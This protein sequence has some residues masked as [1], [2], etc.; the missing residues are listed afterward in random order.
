ME[1]LTPGEWAKEQVKRAP[2][3]AIAT[4]IVTM[5]LVLSTFI[6][7]APARTAADNLSPVE[8][9]IAEEEPDVIEEIDEI[10]PEEPDL[11]P[12]PDAPPV[13]DADAVPVDAPL[14]DMTVDTDF[15]DDVTSDVTE[16]TDPFPME[17]SRKMATIGTEAGTGGFR[18]VL[19]ARSPGGRRSAARR[20][21]MPKGTDKDIL[22]GLRWL[23]KAQNKKTGGWGC[24]QWGGKRD[25]DAGVTGLAL[26]AYLGFGC[27]DKQPAEFASTVK[28]AMKYLVD[29]QKKFGS[30]GKNTGWFGERMYSQGICTMAVSEAYAM[31]GRR[32]CKKSAQAGLDY[33][34]SKQPAY[35]AFSYT[36]PGGDVSVTGFQI[37]AIKSA[38]IAG[39]KVPKEAKDKTLKFLEICMRKDFSTPYGIQPALKVQTKPGKTTMTAATL[40]GRLFMGEKNTSVNS[41]GQADYLMANNRLQRTAQSASCLYEIYYMSLSMFNMGGKYWRTWNKEF[42]K[43]LRA[44]QVKSGPET[45][46]W[47]VKGIR[48][49]G[50]GGRVYST[51][52]ACMALEVYFRYLPTYK[53]FK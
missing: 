33:I 47:P 25:A 28:A 18:G 43:P 36:G 32:G 44:K 22:A 23:K 12:D 39:L 46:S 41:K 2:S 16:P 52:M 3:F 37:Q 29:K 1:Q 24:K 40:T 21:G 30:E 9:E 45:G 11:K 31:T 4:A 42:N 8:A 19:G 26:L 17:L 27:T 38:Y 49:G 20:Y 53:S 7:Y 13:E 5:L 10:Q 35:G 50:H 51:A 34:L 14:D 15:T 48:Y 6:E